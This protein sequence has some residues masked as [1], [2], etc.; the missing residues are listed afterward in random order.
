MRIS[1][2]E[3]KQFVRSHARIVHP[4]TRLDLPER[5]LVLITGD[6]GAGKSSI[7][8][9]VAH[10]GW[11]K[12]LIG[13]RGWPD[14]V[15]S[16]AGVVLYDGV[17]IRRRYGRKARLFLENGP[18]A[19]TATKGQA[20]V[21][22]TYGDFASWRMSSCF[23]RNDLA[24][25]TT[26]TDGERKRLL[27]ALFG[28]SCFDPGLRE[29]RKRLKAAVYLRDE[30]KSGLAVLTGRMKEVS[31]ARSLAKHQFQRLRPP[32]MLSNPVFPASARLDLEPI[33]KKA[34][35]AP[36]P[37]Q[38]VVDVPLLRLQAD[39]A[40][41]A[42]GLAREK[43]ESAVVELQRLQGDYRT[44]VVRHQSARERHARVK[45]GKCEICG[46]DVDGDFST[47]LA[48]RLASLHTKICR[49]RARVADLE[50]E[51]PILEHALHD[52]EATAKVQSR[53]L[54]AATHAISLWDA[55]CAEHAR[56]SETAK[57][58]HAA[59][60]AAV[61]ER[62]AAREKKHAAYLTKLEADRTARLA[63]VR[64]INSQR[65]REY[66]VRKT[67]VESALRSAETDMLG[68]EDQRDLRQKD[69]D[70]KSETVHVLTYAESVLSLRGLR[71]CMLDDGLKKLGSLAQYWLARLSQSRMSVAMTSTRVK[72]DGKLADEISLKFDGAGNG[73][74]A[75]L[76]GGLRV[77]ADLASIF[78]LSEVESAV[79]DRELGTLFCD[80]V[81]DSLDD[82]GREMA[83][84]AMREMSARRP[85]VVISHS[86]HI[87][88][89]LNPD[90]WY[91]VDAKSGVQRIS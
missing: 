75:S 60:C 1:R 41:A 39:N 45:A 66:E 61:R 54:N 83:I 30:T 34:T 22:A 48:E 71:S 14:D 90:M 88:D 23:S 52:A 46:Q 56:Q 4:N 73:S 16:T 82:E 11:G 38:P 85:I 9:G 25:F 62:N 51:M 15:V 57:E 68:L 87:K 81:F 47:S 7:I 78:S 72:R 35:V 65:Q 89:A 70:E 43:K 24:R 53:A 17:T 69:L 64:E 37:M 10:A 13:V 19:D 91:H 58:R 40:A 84:D 59:E 5:G 3:L 31:K 27:E 86:D 55:A 32:Q 26:A 28:L 2:I 50:K 63:E 36:F 12:S 29:V 21:D 6:N 76:S 18:D 42:V 33:P 74:Y 80:E 20:W 67:E 8:D 49:V 44:L 77:K 79:N